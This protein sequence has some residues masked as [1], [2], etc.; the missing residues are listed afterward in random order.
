MSVQLRP[1]ILFDVMET[2]VVEPFFEVASK[3]FAMSKE[4]LLTAK[5]P[6]SWIE[7][8]EGRITE[9]EYFARFFRDG[10]TIDGQAFRARLREAYR[11]VDG[12]ERVLCE[13]KALGYQS[14]ALSNYS[15]WYEMI[16]ASLKL[17]RY[18]EWS[19]VSCRTGVRKPDPQAFLGAAET[20]SVTAKACLF[21][22]DRQVNVDAARAVGIDSILYT[23]TPALRCEME[24]RGIL[25]S[26]DR[27]T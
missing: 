7:F 19:F 6:T 10:R 18:L 22:D 27:K 17:S 20:L 23:G 8:E 4:D 25:L 13:L 11:F 12:M 5:H 24:R 9:G 14:H 15:I 3:F 1:I 16:E 2:L 26:D 21:V